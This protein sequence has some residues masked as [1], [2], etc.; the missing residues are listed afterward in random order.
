MKVYPN[1]YEID[2]SV[3]NRIK[4]INVTDDVTLEIYN[5]AGDLVYYQ[6]Y[7]NTGGNISWDVKNND[8]RDIASGIYFY[9]VNNGKTKGKLVIIK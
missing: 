6:E 9:V 2:K 1:P 3:D 5:L 8:G 7:E 4:F